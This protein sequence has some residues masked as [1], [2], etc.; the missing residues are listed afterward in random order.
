MLE[1][2]LCCLMAPVYGQSKEFGLEGSKL[3]QRFSSS[4]FY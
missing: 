3:E 1:G 4:N 2:S